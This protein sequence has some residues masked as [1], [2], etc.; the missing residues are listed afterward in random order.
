MKILI[1]V[2]IVATGVLCFALKLSSIC[3]R[4]EEEVE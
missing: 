1:A 4:E 2:A 3:A